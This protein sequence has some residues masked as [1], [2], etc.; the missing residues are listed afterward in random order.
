MS[1]L[2]KGILILTAVI[3]DILLLRKL[4]PKWIVV[5]PL[6]NSVFGF[7]FFFWWYSRY[8]AACGAL[9]VMI[10]DN[11]WWWL[12]VSEAEP[13][14]TSGNPF[15]DKISLTKLLLSLPLFPLKVGPICWWMEERSVGSLYS[16]VLGGCIVKRIDVLIML[17]HGWT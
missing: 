7:L 9:R 3:W 13:I 15:I 6:M 4:E 2:L 17:Q 16:G 11:H 12:F 1:E 10:V 14:L 8:W 5:S